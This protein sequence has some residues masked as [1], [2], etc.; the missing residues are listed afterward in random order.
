MILSVLNFAAKVGIVMKT[1]KYFAWQK[2]DILNGTNEMPDYEKKRKNNLSGI[3]SFIRTFLFR[4]VDSVVFK[5]AA[6]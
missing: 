3:F 5:S 1:R 2:R 6:I 4:R